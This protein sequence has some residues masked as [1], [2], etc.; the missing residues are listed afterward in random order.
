MLVSDLI[1]ATSRLYAK[2]EWGPASGEW[3][4][5]SFS[6]RAVANAFS[7]IYTR[8]TDF[9]ISVGTGS[10]KDTLD[11]AHRQRLLSIVDVEPKI[12][13]S[14][15]DLVDP[16]AWERAQQSHP[17][18]WKLSMP[19]VRAWSFDGFPEAR[20]DMTATYQKF[21]NPTTRG[22]PISV[23][24]IDRAT[25][26][27][28]S[29]TPTEIPPLIEEQIRKTVIPTDKLLNQELT[30]I[31]DNILNTVRRAETPRTG[32]YP[33]RHSINY[34][35][36]FQILREAWYKQ[37]GRCNLCGQLITVGEENPLL[38]M[39]P[40]RIDSANKSY[41]SLNVHLTHVGCNLAK[42]AASLEEWHEF[43]DVIRSVH[44]SD[45]FSRVV[46][47]SPVL[48]PT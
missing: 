26:L 4:A 37:G 33:D 13:V 25:L 18:R 9:V 2:S 12:I 43:L 30:R 44:I 42:N 38:K 35:D 20:L 47:A 34:T 15:A 40:D 39:S 22:R 23:E 11:P 29:I 1:G 8:G 16:K 3:P 24:D 10:P 27:R 48:L 31:I 36:L 28:L 17:D 19:I 32:F 5:L 45:E 6:R 41:N 14:T 46:S 21:A 7:G